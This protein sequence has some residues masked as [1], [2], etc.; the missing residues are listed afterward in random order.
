[1]LEMA[2]LWHETG[3]RPKRSVLFVAWGAQELGMVGSRYYIEHALFPL[4]ET[5]AMVQLDAVG[6][7]SGHYMEVQGFREQEGLLMFNM[8]VAEDLVDG[9]L[10]LAMPA[11]L[12][13]PV[14]EESVRE[15]YL[16]PFEGLGSMLL[17]TQPSDQAVFHQLGIPAVLVTWRGANEDNWPDEIAEEVEPYRLDVTGRMVTLVLMTVADEYR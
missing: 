9:R 10:K 5:V 11:E 17:N 8:Q 6:G 2:R 15:L 7:G 4:E 16:S 12:D 1:M 13:Q 3:Y 14:E